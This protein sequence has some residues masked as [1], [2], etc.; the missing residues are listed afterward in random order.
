MSDAPLDLNVERATKLDTATISDALDRLGIAGQCL[1]IKPLD[2]RFRMAGRAFTLAQRSPPISQ[3]AT[4]YGFIAPYI[5]QLKGIFPTKRPWRTG[6]AG[7]LLTAVCA[8]LPV[9]Q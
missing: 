2:H 9:Y 4:I 6:L 1:G 8:T 5:K 3:R 7:W